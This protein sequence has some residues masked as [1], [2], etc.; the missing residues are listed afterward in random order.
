MHRIVL[1][2]LIMLSYKA[3]SQYT[4]P[5]YTPISTS[6]YWWKLPSAFS[7]ISLPAGCDTATA[8]HTLQSRRM[9]AFFTDTCDMVSYVWMGY[10]KEVGS[11]GSVSAAN[12]LTLDGTTVKLGGTI[13]DSITHIQIPVGAK[14]SSNVLSTTYAKVLSNRTLAQ[15]KSESDW[16]YWLRRGANT[17]QWYSRIFKEADGDT[18]SQQYNPIINILSRIVQDHNSSRF[19]SASGN[20]TNLQY[21]G[22]SIGSQLFPVKNIFIRPSVF[23]RDGALFAA[24]F[25]IGRDSSYK[26]AVIPVD[27]EH[28][29]LTNYHSV[30]DYARDVPMNKSR[31]MTGIGIAGYTASWRSYQSSLGT[32]DSTKPSNISKVYDYY[33][34]GSVPLKPFNGQG[35]TKARILARS[36]MDTVIG[37][38]SAPKYTQENEVL[39]GFS[40]MQDGTG[41][42][43]YYG[44]RSRF[45]GSMPNRTSGDTLV[46]EV[47]IYGKALIQGNQQLIFRSPTPTSST[48]MVFYIKDTAGVQGAISHQTPAS[49]DNRGLVLASGNGDGS[50]GYPSSGYGFFIDFRTGQDGDATTRMFRN[51]NTVFARQ[52]T[53]NSYKDFAK[54]VVVGKTLLTDTLTLRR[55]PLITSGSGYDVLVRS[56]SDS[57]VRALPYDSISGGGGSSMLFARDDA[58]NNSGSDMYFSAAG[59]DFTI[60]SV[61]EYSVAYKDGDASSYFN[62]GDSYGQIEVG[63]GDN[64]GSLDVTPYYVRIS[65]GQNSGPATEMFVTLD[66]VRI[67]YSGTQGRPVGYDTTLYKLQA[68]NVVSGALVDTYWPSGGGGGGSGVTTVGTFSG[69]SIANGASISGSTITFG[70]AD[71]T[72]PGMV[73]TGTQT[74]AGVKTFSSAIQANGGIYTGTSAANANLWVATAAGGTSSTAATY[75]FGPGSGA[76]LRV[77]MRGSGAATIT[78]NYDAANMIMGTQ[79]F[80]ESGSGT[81]GVIAG[82]GL[83]PPTI[84]DN[85]ATVTTTATLYIKDAPSTTTTEGNHALMVA[86]GS[87]R[88]GG[89]MRYAY[90]TVSANDN[91]SLTSDH[92]VEVT[93]NSPTLT[94]PSA[95]DNT[96]LTYIF[97]NSGAGTAVIATTSSQVIGNSGSATSM[98]LSAGASLTVVSNGSAWRLP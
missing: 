6:G 90:R 3:Q 69:S 4:N 71:G 17:L 68:R 48:G 36:T 43:N 64:G 63:Y 53:V 66:S 50:L 24:S 96:G 25:S 16:I 58:R 75:L 10:W 31:V 62:L 13:I 76:N 79:V 23:G 49:R 45:G 9:G 73:T 88:F 74:I 19:D 1:L 81:H 41:D 70:P 78:P 67:D 26:I 12:G 77:G 60:D 72:N 91:V 21:S 55:T 8:F 27:E 30:I 46:N 5:P 57:T 98:N 32:A 93:A 38:Y 82:L 22:V 47:E 40:F 7:Y 87:S 18:A 35:F 89:A 33:S 11:G 51:G 28:I 34:A 84:N 92:V 95:T 2:L 61:G 44:G 86:A 54:L 59:K 94:L 20:Q 15:D 42:W 65:S 80:N 52:S 85:A 97:I 37:F 83:M 14:T 29:P 39:N 56:R